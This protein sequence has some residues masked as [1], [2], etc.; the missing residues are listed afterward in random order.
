MAE[1]RGPNPARTTTW[2]GFGVSLTVAL[3]VIG[4]IWT[5]W[6]NMRAQGVVGDF[7]VL[8]QP[9]RWDLTSSIFPHSAT[10]PYWRTLVVSI[11]NTLAAGV[12]AIL[13][14]TGLGI[15]L[16]LVR[17]SGNK[18]LSGLAKV[19]VEI[20][21]NIPVLL[22]IIFWYT[23]LLNGPRVAQAASI[24]GCVFISNRGLY[25]PLPVLSAPGG[26]AAAAAV[27]ALLGIAIA[28]RRAGAG[29]RPSLLWLAASA[30]SLSL[31][32]CV[33]VLAAYDVPVRKGLNFVGGG[34]LTI[35]YLALLVGLT[36]YGAAYI[37][38]IVRGGLNVV[39]KGQIEAARSLGLSK[40]AIFFKV[41]A[42]LALRSIIPPLANQYLFLMKGT[43]LGVAVGFAE[44]F[45]VSVTSI[46]QTGKSID[47]LIVMM[48]IYAVI[49]LSITRAMALANSRL[50]LRG[51]GRG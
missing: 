24:A 43:G 13:F 11:G 8:S 36:L 37:A 40:A 46:N 38:E 28:R 33:F 51:F 1:V 5:T 16:G 10:F 35:E 7:G 4:L 44:V 47:F 22:Q 25:Y 32:V 15:A 50:A 9:T 45:Q 48:L 18:A 41:R 31:L 19:Y 6:T 17:T 30:G 27:A 21:R 42:P 34:H 3:G 2:V 23:L 12:P 49:N 20:F 29:S 26:S 14:S 39:A